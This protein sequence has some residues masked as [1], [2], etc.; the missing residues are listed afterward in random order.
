MTTVAATPIVHWIFEFGADRLSCG[1]E[2]DGSSYRLF[3]VP[4]GHADAAIVDRFHSSAAALQRHAALASRL[5]ERGWAIVS[6]TG[7]ESAARR[8]QSAA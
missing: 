4:N 3:V 2:H 7:R 8:Y 6:Y 5:R 1:V